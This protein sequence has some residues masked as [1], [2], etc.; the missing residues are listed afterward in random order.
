MKNKIVIKMKE[1]KDGSLDEKIITDGNMNTIINGLV[2]TLYTLC[3]NN[4]V[5]LN[6]VCKALKECGKKIEVK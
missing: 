6:M 3:K 4:D 5:D 1:L 2:D